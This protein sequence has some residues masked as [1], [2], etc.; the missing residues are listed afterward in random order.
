MNEEAIKVKVKVK[1]ITE[2]EESQLRG[3]PLRKPAAIHLTM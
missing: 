2:E 1:V 3:K